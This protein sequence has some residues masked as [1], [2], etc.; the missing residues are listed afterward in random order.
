M[1][2]ARQVLDLKSEKQLI[3]RKWSCLLLLLFKYIKYKEEVRNISSGQDSAFCPGSWMP[4]TGETPCRKRPLAALQA[5]H[6]LCFSVRSAS[7]GLHRTRSGQ[8]GLPKT[9][10]K[11]RFAPAWPD[12]PVNN[13]PLFTQVD[14]PK[15]FL[16][17][18][19]SP[20][21]LKKPCRAPSC[22]RTVVLL[23][24]PVDA[25]QRGSAWDKFGDKS[26]TSQGLSTG[27]RF[28]TK[29]LMKLEQLERRAAHIL[30]SS[31]SAWK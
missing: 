23:N 3:H 28:R 24:K 16:T 21:P 1:F 4:V 18:G 25:F 22:S 15:S 19:N 27:W 31:P 8:P 9:G 20:Q 11:P 6:D 26:R 14:A 7:T 2:G 5:P 13:E 10:L 12:S 29:L 17:G 30:Q